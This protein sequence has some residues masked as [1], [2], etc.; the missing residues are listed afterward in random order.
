MNMKASATLRAN[1]LL[2]TKEITVIDH[3]ETGKA[4]RAYRRIHGVPETAFGDIGID[5][6]TLELLESGKW[7]QWDAE[8]VESMKRI[9][10]NYSEREIH[11][12]ANETAK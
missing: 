1:R 4:M 2:V 10:D 6:Y 5:L 8:T 12:S 9:I 7:S 3:V 11:V